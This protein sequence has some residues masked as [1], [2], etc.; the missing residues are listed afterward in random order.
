MKCAS[1]AQAVG[2]TSSQLPRLPEVG[3]SSVHNG[4]GQTRA[5]NLYAHLAQQQ[6][7]AAAA[8]QEM[9][10]LV[11]GSNAAATALQLSQVCTGT[12]PQ[13]RL[14]ESVVAMEARDLYT[15]TDHALHEISLATS[16]CLS[17]TWR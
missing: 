6:L 1:Y 5:G 12:A 7:A 15:C 9:G 3:D 16:Y 17:R 10:G 13:A 14:K 11:R 8:Q 4:N 2:E